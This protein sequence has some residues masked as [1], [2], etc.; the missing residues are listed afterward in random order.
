MK[1]ASRGVAASVM[2]LVLSVNTG[3]AQPRVDFGKSEYDSSCASCHGVDGKGN[4]PVS[5]YLIRQP[6]DLTTL[7]RRHGG[8][9][10]NQMVWEMIDGRASAQIGPHGS[11]EMPIWGMQYR[12]QAAQAGYAHMPEWYVRGRILALLDYIARLQAK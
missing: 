9:F 7:S 8:A 12:L 2:L 3:F 11:R 1:H 10:P 4:G 6:P 5:P